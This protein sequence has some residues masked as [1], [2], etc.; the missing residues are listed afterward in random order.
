[1][2]FTQM[3]NKQRDSEILL[4]KKNPEGPVRVASLKNSVPPLIAYRLIPREVYERIRT[5]IANKQIRIAD[6]PLSN[7]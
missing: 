4:M 6:C 2:Y 1:M 7:T 3:L 5:I